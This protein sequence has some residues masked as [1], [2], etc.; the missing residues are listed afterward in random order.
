VFTGK[1]YQFLA[2]GKPVV[3]ADTAPYKDLQDKVDCI[4]VKINDPVSLAEGI[5]WAY[6]N[7]SKL[8]EIGQNAR[9]VYE[10][11][12]SNQQISLLLDEMF[13]AL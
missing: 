3:I 11:K 9:K 12:Y 5:R 13:K 6:N 10:A 4:K 7:Q 8:H 2:A 1:S